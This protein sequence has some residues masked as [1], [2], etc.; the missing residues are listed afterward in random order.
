MIN[1]WGNY[2]LPL[3]VSTHFHFCLQSIKCDTLPPKLSNYGNLTHLTY[4]FPKCPHHIFLKK[5]KKKEKRKNPKKYARVAEPPH[6]WWPA[7]PFGLGWFGHTQAGHALGQ[8][9]I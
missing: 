7:T 1:L 9:E 6:S 2:I 3:E 5:K 8:T 4:L